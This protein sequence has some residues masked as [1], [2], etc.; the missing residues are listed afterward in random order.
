MIVLVE[1]MVVIVPCLWWSFVL[2]AGVGGNLVT[3]TLGLPNKPF[4][5]KVVSSLAV[6]LAGTILLLGPLLWLRRRRR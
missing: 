1:L 2:Y 6:A 5:I 4:W 3:T